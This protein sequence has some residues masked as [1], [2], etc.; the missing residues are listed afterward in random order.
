V[1]FYSGATLLGSHALTAGVAALVTT[2]LTQ[3]GDDITAV[4]VGNA[5]YDTST[6]PVL[7]QTVNP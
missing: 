6:S 7:L 4:Y 1:K 5:D 3:G 2:K